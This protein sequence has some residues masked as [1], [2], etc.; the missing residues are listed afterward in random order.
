MILLYHLV[1]P[2]DTPARAWNAG[3]IIRLSAFRRQLQ[4]LKRR[5]SFVSL[6]DYVT[7]YQ[8]DP[9]SMRKK[10]ALTFDDGYAHTYALVAPVLQEEGIPA[11]FFT[12]SVNL[13]QGLLWFVYF[14]ALCSERAYPSLEINGRHYPLNNKRNS[15]HAW[16]TLI[17]LARSSPDARVFAEEFAC[18]YPL[19]VQIQEKYAGLRSGQLAEIG[20]SPLFS[21]GGHTHSHP[22]LDQLTQA[23]QLEEMILNKKILEQLS[24][25]MVP[26]FAYPGGVYNQASISA[27]RQAGFLAAFAVSP[28]SLSSDPLFELPRNGVYSPAL[29]KLQLKALGLVDWVRAGRSG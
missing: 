9:K 25:K 19:P 6:K 13:D 5:F 17:Q 22:Y 15:L 12:N 10:L 20:A 28:Q 18:K 11:T 2:D 8:N 23:E 26:Y 1:F 29:W 3:N 24:G 21:L 4:W 14:N 16:K 27:A 7:E